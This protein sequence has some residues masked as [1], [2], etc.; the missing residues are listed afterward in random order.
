MHLQSPKII[1]SLKT[2]HWWEEGE[3]GH[4]QPLMVLGSTVW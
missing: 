4:S 3:Q 1:K 2:V